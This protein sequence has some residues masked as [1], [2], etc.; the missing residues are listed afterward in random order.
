MATITKGLFFGQDYFYEESPVDENTDWK[1]I[2]PVVWA[3]QKV[4]IE[5]IVGTPLYNT[6]EAAVI[7]SSL[8][9]N[10][11][12][13]VN[14]YIAPCLLYYTLSE[15]QVPLTFKYRNRSVQTQRSDS[16][17]PV[18]L[19][20]HKYLKDEYKMIAEK[21]AEKIERYLCANTSLFPDYTTYTS[22]DQVRAQRQRPT[23]SVYLPG[24][25]LDCIDR[26]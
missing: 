21:F 24:I 26:G 12:T 3:C 18:D 6:L 16:T 8:A 10:N 1:L 20:E 7:A 19:T 9:G 23:V 13:L 4:Y 17:D 14:T 22:S 25:D 2:R 11:Q 5:D 15:A